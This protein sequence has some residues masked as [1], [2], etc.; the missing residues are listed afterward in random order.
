M[1]FRGGHIGQVLRRTRPAWATFWATP[2]TALHFAGSPLQSAHGATSRAGAEPGDASLTAQPAHPTLDQLPPVP[3]VLAS[4]SGQ[5]HLS[6]SDELWVRRTEA[7]AALADRQTTM[8]AS[9]AAVAAALGETPVAQF[10]I[11]GY[12]PAAPP[13]TSPQ[14]SDPLEAEAM[15]S[16][17]DYP[18]Q[19]LQAL[20]DPALGAATMSPVRTAEAALERRAGVPRDHMPDA[21]LLTDTHTAT[22]GPEALDPM[23]GERGGYVGHDPTRHGDWVTKSGRVT[24]F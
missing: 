13:M 10:G 11:A 18:G 15:P 12:G 19:S 3:D 7:V 14:S 16:A 2:T 6:L 20:Q 9:N 5:S 21:T 4:D 17:G 24:D 23:T 1:H 22:Y 8:A